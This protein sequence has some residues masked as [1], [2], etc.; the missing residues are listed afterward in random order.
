DGLYTIR[1]NTSNCHRNTWHTLA[2]DHTGDPNGYFM[3]IN[4]SL[5]KSEFYIDTLSGL[6][7]NTTYEFAAWI[8][9][10]IVPSA[11]M[12]NP[13]TPNLTFSIEKIDGTVLQTYTTGDIASTQSPVWNQYGSFFTTPAN[14]SKVV[15][16]LINNSS[17]GC[18]NDLAI[19]DITFRP[20]GPLLV[21]SI[22]DQ[23]GNMKVLCQ[24][25]SADVELQCKVSLGYNNPSFQWQESKDGGNSWVSIPGQ[26]KTSLIRKFTSATPI[27][28]Y[29]YRLNVGE[30]VNNSLALCRVVS[31][32]LSVQV[33]SNPVTSVF[34]NSPAC[35]GNTLTLTA[36]GGI[37]GAQYVWSGSNSFA[38]TGSAVVIKDAQL[39]NAGRYYLKSTNPDGCKHTDSVDV[40]VLPSP[41]ITL[42]FNDKSI[43]KGDSVLLS[44]S[45][46]TTYVWSPASGLSSASI[47][48]PV[49]KPSDSTTYKV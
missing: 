19:D 47:P 1:S 4:A 3:L 38:A 31:A 8:L 16:R 9:N 12:G 13:K 44:S 49:A 11:C 43:C 25:D 34:S 14:I 18:G 22:K 40:A 37:Q 29:L 39:V 48:N 6:C 32:N 35:R 5:Q 17:G 24:G 10:I 42:A 23:P 2:A 20:C 41:L 36:T 21:P 46:G 30:A 45:G 33:N 28:Q 26:T 15:L 7:P 27:G